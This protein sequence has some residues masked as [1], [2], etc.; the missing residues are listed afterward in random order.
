M[1]TIV[2]GSVK[3]KIVASDLLEERKKC[4][5]DQEE[6]KVFLHGGP[7]VLQKKLN[8]LKI[9]SHPELANHHKFYEMTPH[10]Q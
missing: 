10:E 8:Y 4:A 6:L 2:L 3:N 1:T 9:I 7:L 5:F